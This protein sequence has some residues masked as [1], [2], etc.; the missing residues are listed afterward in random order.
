[1]STVFL[2]RTGT[3]VAE[4][5]ACVGVGIT[6]TTGGA[7]YTSDIPERSIISAEYITPPNSLRSI[8]DL[9]ISWPLTINFATDVYELPPFDTIKCEI[10]LSVAILIAF[11]SSSRIV[12][13]EIKVPESVETNNVFPNV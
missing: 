10:V 6:P 5:I 1:M 11:P 9:S 13:P 2:W 12:S 4:L 3:T 8:F 7:A